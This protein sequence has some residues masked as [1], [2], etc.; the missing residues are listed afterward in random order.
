MFAILN[1]IKYINKKLT[2]NTSI[3]ICTD[4]QSA[5]KALQNPNSTTQ[6]VQEILSEVRTAK[7]KQ[8]K[9]SFA[10]TRAHVGD[11]GNE[12]TD[13]L[14]KAAAVSH[15]SI[16]YD[17]IPVLRQKT[18]SETQKIFSNSLP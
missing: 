10:W 2:I 5:I 8:I 3:T 6:L 15:Q 11:T 18:G 7:E 12:L 9:I 4:S 14:A 13:N 1:A 17:L 16:S